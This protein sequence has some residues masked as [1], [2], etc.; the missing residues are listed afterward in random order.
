VLVGFC[1]V[2]ISYVCFPCIGSTAASLGDAL[3]YVE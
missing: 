2:Q 3:Q 1:S